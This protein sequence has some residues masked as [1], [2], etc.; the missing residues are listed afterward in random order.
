MGKLLRRLLSFVA[1][2]PLAMGGTAMASTSDGFSPVEVAWE[3]AVAQ[4]T[5]EA[6]AEFAMN[7]PESEFARN[8]H[9]RL[10][11]ATVSNEAGES[12]LATST[13]GYSDGQSSVPEVIPDSI[14]AGE[15]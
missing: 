1:I 8:A 5:L 14:M 6:Y 7:H 2:A 9:A 3:Q 11:G 10:T 4:N 13:A 12:I 15:Y